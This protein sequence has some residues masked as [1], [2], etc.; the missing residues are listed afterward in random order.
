MLKNKKGLIFA[1]FEIFLLRRT[2]AFLFFIRN[3]AS[4]NLGLV[5]TISH[6]SH[7][8]CLWRC[9]Q[10]GGG[11]R[12]AA[13]N[14]TSI[15]YFSNSTSYSLS[16]FLKLL[17]CFDKKL[18]HMILHCVFGPPS[19]LIH[20]SSVSYFTY[21]TFS[22]FGT[23]F[24]VPS[25]IK[26]FKTCHILICILHT[27]VGLMGQMVKNSHPYLELQHWILKKLYF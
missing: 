11:V 25:S 15:V 3:S 20:S 23:S 2:P 17:F 6:E 18:C 5:S 14:A 9:R 19:R 16:P 10:V 26:F 13:R 24:I 21:F 1:Q 22:N 12:W 27:F 8:T 7:Q 4:G